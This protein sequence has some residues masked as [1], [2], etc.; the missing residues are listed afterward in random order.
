MRPFVAAPASSGDFFQRHVSEGV[1]LCFNELFLANP[2]GV[3][4]S[5]N[6]LVVVAGF[7]IQFGRFGE[8]SLNPLTYFPTG[9]RV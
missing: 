8:G 2:A 9:D 3:M 7:S 1:S 6:S 5:R 4:L